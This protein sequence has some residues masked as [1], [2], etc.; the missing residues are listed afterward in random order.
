MS[1]KTTIAVSSVEVFGVQSFGQDGVR[2]TIEDNRGE[3]F[4]HVDA[5]A[6]HCDDLIAA[7]HKALGR[8]P[9]AL[10]VTVTTECNGNT[11]SIRVRGMAEPAMSSAPLEERITRAWE[12][13][14]NEAE[15]HPNRERAVYCDGTAH[16]LRTALAMVREQGPSTP[17]ADQLID[18]ANTTVAD[19]S[20]LES[21]PMRWEMLARGAGLREAAGMVRAAGPTVPRAAVEALRARWSATAEDFAAEVRRMPDLRL[22]DGAAQ[23]LREV[24]VALDALLAAAAPSAPKEGA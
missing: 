17:L 18:A 12:K 2:V 10:P 8:P 20:K 15:A 9:P 16:G 22:L 3:E 23:A 24:T 5:T 7:L 11:L 6:E 19:A 14:K 21:G 13:A 1:K 4:A